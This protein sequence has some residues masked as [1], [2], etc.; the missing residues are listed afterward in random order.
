MIVEVMK[1]APERDPRARKKASLLR[2]LQKLRGRR[3]VAQLTQRRTVCEDYEPRDNTFTNVVF[4]HLEERKR[5]AVFGNIRPEK[6][7]ARTKISM[8]VECVLFEKK[9]KIFTSMKYSTRKGLH[10]LY[11]SL[12]F[13]Q[14]L[15]RSVFRLYRL[16]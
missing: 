6:L 15:F 16:N 12:S 8:N 14:I 1:L 3:C 10:T 7:D 13:S 4:F 2:R 9:N 5:G 11:F